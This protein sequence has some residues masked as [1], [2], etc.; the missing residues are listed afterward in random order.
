MVNIT[1]KKYKKR[2]RAKKGN[3]NKRHENKNQTTTNGM[4]EKTSEM[5]KR[6]KIK[7]I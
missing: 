4:T 3:R 1:D 6:N 7:Y 5:R 2:K